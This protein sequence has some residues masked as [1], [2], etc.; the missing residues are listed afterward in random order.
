MNQVAVIVPTFNRGHILARA[1]DSVFSQTFSDWELIVVDDGSTD[2]TEIVVHSWLSRHRPKQKV[3][4]LK[5]PNGGVSRARNFGVGLTSAPW[6]AFLD[7]DDEWLPGKLAQQM[8]LAPRFALIHTGEIW[9]RKGVRVN[10]M[11]KH[12]KAG[13]RVFGACVEQCFISPSTTLLARDLFLAHGGFREDFPVCEDYD[14]WLKI[15]AENDIGFVETPLIKKYGGDPSQL[16]LSVPAMDYYRVKALAGQLHN[17]YLS[18][19][20]KLKAAANLIQRAEILLKGFKKYPNANREYEIQEALHNARNAL[21]ANHSTHSA[22]DRFPR[23]E[24]RGTL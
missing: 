24:F 17:Q 19:E 5:V 10:A 2:Q 4:F 3:Q 12:A 6:L 14:L 21:T 16:S 22:A 20:E 13:G 1:L 23:S 9:I 18:T 7:S 11:K 15:C 8:Q